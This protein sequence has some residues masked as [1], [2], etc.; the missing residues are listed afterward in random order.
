MDLVADVLAVVLAAMLAL[1]AAL[2]IERNERSV[3]VV[4]ELARVPLTLFPVLAAVELTGA[5]GVILGV[6]STPIGIV[7]CMGAVAYFVGA[8]AAH[9]MA[10]HAAAISKPLPPAALAVAALAFRIAAG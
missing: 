5:V 2:K 1:S 3:Y 9:V 8:M 10:G 6:W 7:A 4:H